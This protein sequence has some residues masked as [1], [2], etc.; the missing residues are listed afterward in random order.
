[1]L[2]V[3]EQQLLDALEPRA[4]QEHLEIVTIEIVGAKKSPTIRIYLDTQDGDEIIV[5]QDWISD[6]VEAID[7]FPGAYML[8]VSTP[9]IDRP[10]RTPEHFTQ[11]AGE[12][13]VIHTNEH[14]DG[15]SRFAGVLK[16]FDSKTSHIYIQVNGDLCEIPYNLVKKAHVVGKISFS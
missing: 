10:L 2:S 6:I 5:A 13:V 15:I 12:D 8:E 14:I 11:Y 1:M 16:G 4:Q 7:P 3:K 9:G